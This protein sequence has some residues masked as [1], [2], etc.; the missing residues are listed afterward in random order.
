MGVPIYIHQEGRGHEMRCLLCLLIQHEAIGV[1][2]QRPVV[3]VEEHLIWK[4]C[5]EKQ[6]T[7][8]DLASQIHC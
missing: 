3:C 7:L 6:Q 2:D 8:K 4:L 5:G 1:P